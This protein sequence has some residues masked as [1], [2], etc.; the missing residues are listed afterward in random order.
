MG[1][2]KAPD[3][4][5]L[6]DDEQV[7]IKRD[8]LGRPIVT[9]KTGGQIG[10]MSVN[11]KAGDVVLSCDD[12]NAAT[13]DDL[14]KYLPL[15]G[16]KMDNMATISTDN[17]LTLSAKEKSE[18]SLTDAGYIFMQGNAGVYVMGGEHT[19]GFNSNGTV[20]FGNQR[21][22]KAANPTDDTDVATK[23]YVDNSTKDQTTQMKTMEDTVQA[24]N[25]EVGDCEKKL[26][27]FNTRVTDVEGAIATKLTLSGGTMEGNI[28]MNDYAV[29]NVQKIHVDGTTPVYIGSV[30]EQSENG[31]RLT[32]TTAGEAAFVK[33]STQSS[34]APVFGG[35][36]TNVNHLTT[37]GYVD[38]SLNA[39]IPKIPSND[40]QYILTA[41]NGELK[42]VLT[43]DLD[44]VDP[45]EGSVT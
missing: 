7:E 45:T 36:P 12:L 10:V 29:T 5:Y 17:M 13:K 19:V 20:D 35:T 39:M 42:W 33:P 23:K 22:V 34:Y 14:A 24:L 26:D 32:S 43:M 8:A 37:K 2:F 41:T 31:V 25:S 3:G 9:L 11:G 4:A 18:L 40:K 16:G 21:I 15:A 6:F 1:Y 38:N 30:I 28:D 27:N 44:Y